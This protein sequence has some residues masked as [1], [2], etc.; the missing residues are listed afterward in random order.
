MKILTMQDLSCFGESSL[1]IALPVLTAFGFETAVLPSA[2]LS[3]QTTG[4]DQ[5]AFF[6]L[7][8]EV[9]EIVKVWKELGI[10]FDAFYTGYIADPDQFDLILQ[11]KE[12]LLKP[13]GVFIVDPAM[14]DE[15]KLYPGLDQRW[16]EGM[17][18]LCSQADL[19]IPNFTEFC[20]LMNEKPDEIKTMNALEDLCDKFYEKTSIPDL[21][22]T[23]IPDLE[24]ETTEPDPD[25]GS[26]LLYEG[27]EASFY[28]VHYQRTRRLDGCGDLFASLLTALYCR[29]RPD[30]GLDLWDYIQLAHNGVTR[31][32]NLTLQD[33]DHGYGPEF[34]KV[35]LEHL[36]IDSLLAMD[37]S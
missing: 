16:I 37:E 24:D 25:N 15:G 8:R 3:N 2:L 5:Y 10:Q 6:P 36:D 34:E 18:K 31:I 35:L 32:L 13:D 11:M 17:R 23:S 1:G 14:A 28:F 20:F 26:I 29:N 27:S 12:E 33:Q 9:K 7:T 21:V 30:S 22:I 19:I 4:Y